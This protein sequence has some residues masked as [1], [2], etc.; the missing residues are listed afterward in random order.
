LQDDVLFTREMRDVL[1]NAMDAALA[2]LDPRNDQDAIDAYLSAKD[3]VESLEGTMQTTTDT[4]QANTDA[5]KAHTDA[6]TGVQD[7]LKRQTDVATSIQSTESF[8]L[9]RYL[10]E[11]VSGEFGRNIVQRGLTAGTGPEWTP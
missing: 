2:D 9:K 3:A 4:L 10:A 5:M 8:Q 11:V 6:L 1:K 7:E